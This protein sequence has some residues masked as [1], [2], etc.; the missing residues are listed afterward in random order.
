[1]E[2]SHGT[3][4]AATGDCPVTEN[5][6]TVEIPTEFVEAA[7]A[8][9][10]REDSN[11]DNVSQ[12]ER[13]AEQRKLSGLPLS[14]LGMI[15]FAALVRANEVCVTPRTA[16]GTK[17]ALQTEV[18]PGITALFVGPLLDSTRFLMEFDD[19]SYTHGTYAKWRVCNPDE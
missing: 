16:P 2:R 12:I 15:T 8:H 5:M 17:I 7:L 1:M 18:S 9:F 3:Q 13:A 10:Y 6:T 14:A 19:G 11:Y 4:R